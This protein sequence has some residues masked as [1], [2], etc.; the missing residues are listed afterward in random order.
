MW[1]KSPSNVEVHMMDK[2]L[3]KFFADVLYAKRI[4]CAEELEA[5]YEASSFSDLDE[6]FE[7]MLGGEYN[8]YKRGETYDWI[9]PRRCD[10]GNGIEYLDNNVTCQDATVHTPLYD[11][12]VYSE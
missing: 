12:A 1:D 3:L 10:T 9:K 7:K 11:G 2:I 5:I 8:V 6:I 4:L